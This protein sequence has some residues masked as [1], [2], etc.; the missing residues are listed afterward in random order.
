MD[1]MRV[2]TLQAPFLYRL[3]A[4]RGE[5][6]WISTAKFPTYE[7][8]FAFVERHPYRDWW[9]IY[10]DSKPVGSIYLGK[11]N[12]V[13]VVIAKDHRRSG[14]AKQAIERVLRDNDPLPAI[15]SVRAGHFIANIK[16]GNQASEALFTACGFKPIQRT[17]GLK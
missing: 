2:S 16:E 14:Y 7:E 17:W 11:D 9:V 6:S 12:S 10:V 5:D 15:K 4:E 13:G 1:L 8:H 3:F